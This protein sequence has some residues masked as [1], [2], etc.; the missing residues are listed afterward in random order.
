M[1]THVSPTGASG[2][3]KPRKASAPKL[4]PRL[5]RYIHALPTLPDVILFRVGKSDFKTAQ[6]SD[7]LLKELRKK[8]NFKKVAFQMKNGLIFRMTNGHLSDEGKQ[9]LILPYLGNTK[10]NDKILR[11]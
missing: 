1:G 8:T 3:R 2:N 11:H 4:Y 7:T 6:E 10:T 9:L 5:L